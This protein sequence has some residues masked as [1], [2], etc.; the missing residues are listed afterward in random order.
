MATMRWD[1]W[2]ELASLQRDVNQLFSGAAGR[3]G[4]MV[5][6][7]DAYRTAEGVVVRL[8]LPGL[9]PDDVD[10]SV[11]D[12]TMTIAGERK[13]D[14]AIAE[15]AWL[16][17]ERA[18]GRFER[19]FTLPQGTDPAGIA[20]SFEHGVL[21]LRIPHP[22]ERRPHKVQVSTGGAGAGNEAIDVGGGTG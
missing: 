20:A 16:R 4:G 2:G 13:V 1:P 6:P 18:V 12:G 15:D 9:R 22:P 10:V 17:R 5:P 21:E 7:M 14:P 8:E 11:S 3:T 19:S